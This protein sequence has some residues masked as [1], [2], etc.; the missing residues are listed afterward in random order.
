M[1]FTHKARKALR[2][3]RAGKVSDYV[4][5]LIEGERAARAGRP[6][7]AN[8]YPEGTEEHASWTEGYTDQL[9]CY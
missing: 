5:L 1:A 3:K 8:P 6:I 9:R 2:D 4:T 7:E